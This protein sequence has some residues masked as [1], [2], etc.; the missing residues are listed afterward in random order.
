LGYTDPVFQRYFHGKHRKGIGD[1]KSAAVAEWMQVDL[2][3]IQSWVGGCEVLGGVFGRAIALK[4]IQMVG[5]C[6]EMRRG[7]VQR[8]G[9]RIMVGGSKVEE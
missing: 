3:R 8:T 2:S 7:G 1:N 6:A 5:G 4:G 9:F